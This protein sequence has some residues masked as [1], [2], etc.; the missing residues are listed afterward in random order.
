MGLETLQ[1]IGSAIANALGGL[2]GIGAALVVAGLAILLIIGAS[3]GIYLFIRLIKQI[4]NMTIWE[5]VKFT[6]IFAVALVVIGIV[7]P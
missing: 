7:L 1:E 3:I 2:K 6:V 4:P 5:F